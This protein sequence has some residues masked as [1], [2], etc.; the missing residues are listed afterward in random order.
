MQVVE[1]DPSAKDAL[2]AIS[3]L[4]AASQ[5]KLEAQKEEMISKLKV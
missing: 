2:K 1:L 3:R 5:A 4:E